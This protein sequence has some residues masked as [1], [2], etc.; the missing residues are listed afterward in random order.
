MGV[1]LVEVFDGIGG[2]LK[3]AGWVLG[4]ILVMITFL[5]DLVL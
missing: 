2:V 4:F 1:L 3:V 5:P